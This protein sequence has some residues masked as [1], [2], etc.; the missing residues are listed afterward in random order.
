MPNMATIAGVCRD[1]RGDCPS[2]LQKTLHDVT[3]RTFNAISV[4]GD[5]STNDTLLV[6]A[7]GES[8]RACDQS[9]DVRASSLHCR[10]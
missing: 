2:L 5:T 1:G 10:A 4:D 6:L 3:G 7:N 9:G 8:R